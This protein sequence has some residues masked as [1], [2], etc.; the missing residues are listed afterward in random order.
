MAAL[1]KMGALVHRAHWLTLLA[2]AV[3]RTGDYAQA[4]Q[5]IEEALTQVDRSGECFYEA[6]TWRIKGELNLQKFKVQGSEFK[7]GDG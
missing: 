5:L 4:L 3:G 1:Q 7:G 6:E 2:E